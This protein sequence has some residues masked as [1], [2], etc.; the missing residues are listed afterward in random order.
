MKGKIFGKIRR[1]A[2]KDRNTGIFGRLSLWLRALLFS[3]LLLSVTGACENFM[4]D[5]GENSFKKAV[6]DAVWNATAPTLAITITSSYGRLSIM[7]SHTAKQK[8]PF[9]LTFQPAADYCFVRWAAYSGSTP[10]GSDVVTF[11]PPTRWKPR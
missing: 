1:F 7:G 10:L 5:N 11:T 9:S 3:A 4:F 8:V 6:E 2:G